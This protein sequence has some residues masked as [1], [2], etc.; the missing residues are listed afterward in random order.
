MKKI[1]K[2]VPHQ[3]FG[4][5][6]CAVIVTRSFGGRIGSLRYSDTVILIRQSN[7]E[8]DRHQA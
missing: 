3:F 6:F 5:F 8:R 1:D 7:L 2:A 4:G